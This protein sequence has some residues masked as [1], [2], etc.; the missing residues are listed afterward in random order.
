MHFSWIAHFAAQHRCHRHRRPRVDI[1]AP[2]L[3]GKSYLRQASRS[4]ST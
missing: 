2:F 3:V 4:D 1:T